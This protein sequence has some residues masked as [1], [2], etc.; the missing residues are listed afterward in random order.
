MGLYSAVSAK[1]ISSII[2]GEAQLYAQES[3]QRYELYM[4]SA[5]KDVL[6]T[7]YSVKPELLFFDDITEDPEDWRNQSLTQYY[8]LASVALIAED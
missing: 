2:S 4:Q 8:D 6:V 5:G 3:R 7:P 1:A